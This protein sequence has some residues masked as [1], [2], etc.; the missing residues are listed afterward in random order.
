M[1][2]GL[3]AIMLLLLLQIAEGTD[4]QL[5]KVSATEILSKISNGQ[6]VDYDNAIIIG[7]LLLGNLEE[8]EEVTTI[9]SPIKIS[10]SVFDGLVSFDNVIFENITDFKGS[11]FKRPANFRYSYFNSSADFTESK[12]N[13][14]SDFT[15]SIFKTHPSVPIPEKSK[16]VIYFGH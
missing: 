15:K 5:K 16:M 11:H 6:P 10:N 8:S 3:F 12:F 2:L 1:K 13:D 7:N 14:S 4:M 9:E